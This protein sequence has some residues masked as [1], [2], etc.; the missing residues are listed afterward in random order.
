MTRL[1]C[2]GIFNYCFTRKLLQSMSV[3]EFTKWLACGKV[4]DENRVVS[5]SEHGVF[6]APQANRSVCRLMNILDVISRRS[7]LQPCKLNYICFIRDKGTIT[8]LWGVWV[9]VF[10]IGWSMC[11]LQRNCTSERTKLPDV[12]GATSAAECSAGESATCQQAAVHHLW[13]G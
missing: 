1:R 12:R 3:K 9:L 4:R 13:H 7:R 2:G 10:M 11:K 5:F 6:A 8:T